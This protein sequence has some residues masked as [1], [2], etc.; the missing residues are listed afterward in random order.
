[1]DALVS[2]QPDKKRKVTYTYFPITMIVMVIEGYFESIVSTSAFTKTS[3][4]SIYIYIY[5][6]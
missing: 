4:Q 3:I 5:N 6:K 2:M 1:M